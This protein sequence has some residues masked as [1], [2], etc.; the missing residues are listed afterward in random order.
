MIQDYYLQ[1]RTFDK[2]R[3]IE[4]G[5][6]MVVGSDVLPPDKYLYDDDFYS[7][8]TTTETK[9]SESNGNVVVNQ[10]NSLFLEAKDSIELKAGFKATKG[11]S[12]KARV[13]GTDPNKRSDNSGN[14]GCGRII[15]SNIQ[16]EIVY[17]VS[18]ELDVLNWNLKGYKTNISIGSNEFTIPDYIEKGQY[19]LTAKVDGC[20]PSSIVVVQEK[21][22]ELNDNDWKEEESINTIEFTLKPNPA[23]TLVKI[24]SE[25]LFTKVKISN[26]LG[27]VLFEQEIE[28]GKKEFSIE[29]SDFASGTYFIEIK[30][31]D[32][33]LGSKKLVVQH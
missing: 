4:C 3:D 28:T 6:K 33:Y 11:S 31:K 8:L 12:F 26:V 20:V 19:S 2:D 9:K 21:I 13:D 25:V 18:G 24:D 5:G 14:Q 15:T 10:G 7:S 23:N 1:N 16:N 29:I 32:E 27:N 22:S 30:S 17:S